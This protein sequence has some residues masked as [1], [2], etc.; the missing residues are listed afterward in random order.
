MAGTLD[1]KT[2]PLDITLTDLEEAQD[3]KAIEHKWKLFES[4]LDYA[5]K[6]FD[7]H[8]K[9]RTTMFNFFLLFTGLVINGYIQL[10]KGKFF[11][12]SIIVALAGASISIIFIFLDRRNEEL[13][14]IAEDVL[15]SLEKDVMFPEYRRVVNYPN[16]R[17]I[18]GK[19]KACRKERPLGILLRQTKD[20]DEVGPSAY[21]HGYWLPV[22]QYIIAATFF[23]LAI[24]SMRCWQN[25][26]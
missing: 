5:W 13:V 3:Y 25:I 21:A 23:I 12:L 9:Q 2:H 11:L 6:Y 14:H 17:N 26:C 20:K 24:Y 22:I 16:R 15:E 7:F 10:Q 18:F 1:G 4:R 8:A 19:I